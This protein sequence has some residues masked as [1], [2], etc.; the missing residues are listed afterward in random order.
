MI[1]GKI[2]ATENTHTLYST[3]PSST[4]ILNTIFDCTPHNSKEIVDQGKILQRRI[5]EGKKI[6]SKYLSRFIKGSIASAH[7]RQIVEDELK[8]VQHH[9]TARTVCK[10]FTGTITQKDGVITVGDVRASFQVKKKSELQKAKVVVQRVLDAL[11]KQKDLEHKKEPGRLKKFWDILETTNQH[12]TQEEKS[13]H[14][15]M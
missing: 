2:R 5:L 15:L 3:T 8:T 4:P 6:N 11:Q 10:K 13:K 1:L 7:S 9:A 12:H 14:K